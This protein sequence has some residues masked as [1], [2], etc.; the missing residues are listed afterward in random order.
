VRGLRIVHTEAS[1]GWGGQEIRILSESKGL[2]D[3]GHGVTLL[4]PPEARIHAEAPRW[5]VPVV[6]LPIGRKRPLGVKV[7][8][9]W[10]KRNR[11]DVVCTHSSTD[12]WLVAFALLAL[13]RPVP[14]VRTRHVSAPV[15]SNALAR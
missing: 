4:C 12:A 11:C 14:M 13:G 10:L 6:A 8:Y 1:L 15:P 3:R 9:E 7:L 5:R 2:I